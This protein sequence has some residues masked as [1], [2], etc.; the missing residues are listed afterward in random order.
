M[1]ILG[2]LLRGDIKIKAPIV[3]ELHS[4]CSRVFSEVLTSL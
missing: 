1:Q 4:N 2:F 3:L